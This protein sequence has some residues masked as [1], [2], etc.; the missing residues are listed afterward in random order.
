[1]SESNQNRPEISEAVLQKRKKRWGLL[2][3]ASVPLSAVVAWAA[4][5]ST[6]S[7]WKSVEAGSSSYVASSQSAVLMVG[8]GNALN[9][10][11]SAAIGSSL[12]TDSSDSLVV[13]RF[14]EDPGDLVLPN[15]A[16]IFVLGKGTSAEK[17]NAMEVYQDGTVIINERQ[18]D[19]PMGIYGTN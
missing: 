19:I 4:S 18:G 11:N 16:T 5:G 1:M 15:A 12:A 7:Y 10:S 14:N 6:A 9:A 8:F 13:G 3:L 17:A 2:A